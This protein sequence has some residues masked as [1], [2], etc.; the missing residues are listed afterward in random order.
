GQIRS[1]AVS[2]HTASIQRMTFSAVGELFATAN[3]TSLRDES[4]CSLCS[5]RR[6]PFVQFTNV[7]HGPGKRGNHHPSWPNR[8]GTKRR[9]VVRATHGPKP[10]RRRRPNNTS[11]ARK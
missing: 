5:G 4:I 3:G 10:S 8:L 11:P 1:I 6:L 7:T 2:Y 9:D